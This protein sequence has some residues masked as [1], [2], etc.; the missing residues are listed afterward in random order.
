MK[1]QGIHHVTA[2]SARINENLRFYTKVLGMRLV[3]KSVNQDD[4]SAY[5]L[6][7][8]DAVGS[9]GSDLTF[10]DWP[11]I[12]AN[13][14]GL[15]SVALTT[16]RIPGDSIDL[17][18]VRLTESGVQNV[19][20]TDSAGRDRLKFEDHEG[21]SLAFVD[22][23]GIA[24]CV[25]PW[26]KEVPIEMA[27]R[28]IYGVDIESS[29]PD[30]TRRVLTEILGYHSIDDIRFESV[31]DDYSS[32]I[33]VRKP[34]GQGFGQVGAGGVHHVA[35]QVRDDDEL[36][37]F[38]DRIESAGIRTSGAIDRFYFHSLY[39][40]EPGGVLFELATSGPGFASDEDEDH[41]GEK[42][43]LPP[44]LE[45]QRLQIE[46]NLKPLDASVAQ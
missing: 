43:A 16:L 45:A 30:L 34:S 12:Q 18:Q 14:P 25:I 23:S 8:A 40:R 35:F 2:V 31:G 26:S 21:Q 38:Q 32:E 37:A 11:A 1:V 7:Y 4:V 27:I 44:F 20:D 19:R 6:F 3:K 42:L 17:W 39:F 41:L 33:I 5:H 36:K 10:F 9:P 15:G 24:N 13:R 29:R 46:S 28:G 22:D